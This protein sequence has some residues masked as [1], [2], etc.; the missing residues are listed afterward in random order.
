[1]V[2]RTSAW[3]AVDLMEVGS[4][5][6]RTLAWVAVVSSEVVIM[7]EDSSGSW[8]ESEAARTSAF[9]AVEVMD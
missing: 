6:A 1:M 3:V 5:M 7:V 8:V 4:V 9:K 2:A